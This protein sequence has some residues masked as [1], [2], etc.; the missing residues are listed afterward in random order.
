MLHMRIELSE[1]WTRMLGS[2]LAVSPCAVL[3]DSP[4]LAAGHRLQ[5]G[6]AIEAR[7]SLGRGQRERVRRVRLR[8]AL[9]LSALLCCAADNKSQWRERPRTSESQ[10]RGSRS[11]RE[12]GIGRADW[13][14]DCS[15]DER[16]SQQPRR[17]GEKR[18]PDEVIAAHKRN[19]VWELE[20]G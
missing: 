18:P 20:I 19:P 8:S 14:A 16:R 6:S 3:G 15:H 1:R 17:D 12:D 2:A 5:C 9:L 7:G 4:A 11:A 13:R 10:R